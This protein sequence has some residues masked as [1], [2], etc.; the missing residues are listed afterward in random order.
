MQRRRLFQR[1]SFD[2]VVALDDVSFRLDRGRCLALVGPNGAGKSTLL[3]VLSTT[4]SPTRGRATIYGYDVMERPDDVRA[5][6]GFAA[7]SDRSFFWPLTG[8]ENLVF[9]GQLAGLGREQAES[10]A[11]GWIKRVGL[12]RAAEARV[13]GYSAGMRQRLGLVRALLHDPP[14]VLLDEPTANLDVEYREVTVEILR[15]VLESERGVVVATHDPSLV[16][17]VAT[18]TLR[19]ENGRVVPPEV[20]L[21][22]KRYVLRLAAA[23]PGADKGGTIEVDDLGD[24]HALSA[25]LSQAIASGLDVVSVEHGPS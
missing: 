19:L 14:V 13:S 11:S 1:R 3:R 16:S 9:F 25:A 15:E 17:A 2:P 20:A 7:D 23:D 12:G 4:I 8:M 21:S 5:H 18:D 10:A 24:G 6:L 22:P